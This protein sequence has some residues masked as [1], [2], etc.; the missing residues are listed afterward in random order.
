MYCN[1]Q[2]D[3]NIT[4]PKIFDRALMER[5][6]PKWNFKQWIPDV[7]VICLGLNDFSGL[8]D[9]LGTVSKEKS[10]S[11]RTTYHRFI[12][13]LRNVYPDV[14]I[15]AVAAYPEWI[16]ANI[17][18]IVDEERASG[19]SDIFYTTFDE[20]P[21]GYVANGHPTVATHQKIADQLIQAMESFYLFS[22]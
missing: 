10:G 3:T 12:Q 21:G 11:F 1:W 19:Y 9:S 17:K 6:E 8:K 5:Q 16:R 13:T 4:I 15:V 14:K 7:A 20:F 18:Q 2:G 22:K